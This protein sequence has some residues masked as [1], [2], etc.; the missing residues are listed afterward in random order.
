MVSQYQKPNRFS[1]RVSVSQAAVEW[2]SLPTEQQELITIEAGIPFLAGVP[3]L[4]ER[5]EAIAEA[6]SRGGI[7]GY[8]SNEDGYPLP[9]DRMSLDRASVLKWISKVESNLR[10]DLTI[11]SIENIPKADQLIRVETVCQMLSI[12]RSTLYRYIESGKFEDKH[13]EKPPRWRLSY[14]EQFIKSSNG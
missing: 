13:S 11:A 14:V 6:A 9:A 5:A 1:D 2:Q 4:S 3:D 12:S 8:V 7:T 10:T